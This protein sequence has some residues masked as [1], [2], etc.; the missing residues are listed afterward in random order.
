MGGR[1]PLSPSQLADLR[2]LI[3]A[4]TRVTDNF[5]DDQDAPHTE[6]SRSIPEACHIDTPDYCYYFDM[7]PTRARPDVKLYI[8]ARFIGPNDLVI[9]NNLVAWMRKKGRGAF[10]DNY[11]R[12]LTSVADHRKLEDGKGMHAYIG[13]MFNENGELDITSY[14]GAEVY[15]P[16]RM[17]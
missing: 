11:L 15:S 5:L 12:M 13:I 9:A 10:G 7:A 8:P 1:I 4:V 16:Q 14:I 3:S 17:Q 6:D 2:S